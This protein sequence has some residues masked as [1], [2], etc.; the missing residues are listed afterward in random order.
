[1]IPRWFYDA[2]DKKCMKFIYGGLGGN[3]NNFLSKKSCENFCRGFFSFKLR[4]D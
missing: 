4:K 2:S 1:M 3:E